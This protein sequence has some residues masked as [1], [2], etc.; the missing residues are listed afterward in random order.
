MKSKQNLA[1]FRLP[2]VLPRSPDENMH[3]GE[4]YNFYGIVIADMRNI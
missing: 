3:T 4:P 2:G 1:A